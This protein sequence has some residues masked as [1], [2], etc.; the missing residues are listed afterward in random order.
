MVCDYPLKGAVEGRNPAP[1]EVGSLS[2]Y[3]QGFMH[4]T[5]GWPWNC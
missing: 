4:L 3:F 5:G 1:V 2:H